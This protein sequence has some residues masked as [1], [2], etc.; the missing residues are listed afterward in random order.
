MLGGMR[1]GALQRLSGIVAA[2][3]LAA[4]AAFALGEGQMGGGGGEMS[5]MKIPRAEVPGDPGYRPNVAADYNR[6]MR[7]FRAGKYRDAIASFD[8]VVRE[9]PRNASAWTMLGL[10]KEGAGDLQ[11]AHAAYA[12]AVRFDPHN[13]GARQQLGVTAARLGRLDE[14]RA[15]LDELQKRAAAC[16][17]C[18][19]A[20]RLKA[21][22]AAV[23]DAIAAGSAA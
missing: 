10:S 17:G 3:T 15:E 5:Q 23:Q 18:P 2:L 9:A 13:V 6:G 11:G 21:A 4:G 8:L 14:A 1:K 16:N 12:S 20:A 7:A 19:D 22:I